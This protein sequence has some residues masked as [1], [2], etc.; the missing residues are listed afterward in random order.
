MMLHWAC[1]FS[2][3]IMTLSDSC[4]GLKDLVVDLKTDPNSLAHTLSATII[5]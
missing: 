4:L 5:F 1:F 2:D 3:K